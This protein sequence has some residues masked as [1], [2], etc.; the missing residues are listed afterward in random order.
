M[1]KILE[2]VESMAEL[3]FTPEE[4]AIIIDKNVDVFEKEEFEKAYFRGR[5]KAQAD[6][7]KSIL[8]MAKQGSSPAQKEF[9]KLCED[10][11]VDGN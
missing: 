9:Q 2:T 10:S 11:E 7:R 8:Q 3:Q 1:D 5:L 4:I 6:V